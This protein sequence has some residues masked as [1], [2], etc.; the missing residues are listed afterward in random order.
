M[1]SINFPNAQSVRHI[2]FLEIDLGVQII[3][4]KDVNSLEDQKV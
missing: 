1:K 3:A 4:T 2:I